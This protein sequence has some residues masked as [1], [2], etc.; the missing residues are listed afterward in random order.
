MLQHGEA[1][2]GGRQ[3]H[4]PVPVPPFADVQ[5]TISAPPVLA[6]AFNWGAA[7]SHRAALEYGTFI[8]AAT[9]KP[10]YFNKFSNWKLQSKY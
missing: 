4:A 5:R 9:S 7:C 3:D 10:K 1:L 2:I 6:E 8:M